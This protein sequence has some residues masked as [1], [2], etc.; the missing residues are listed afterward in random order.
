MVLSRAFQTDIQD[1]LEAFLLGIK[2]G[3]HF[4]I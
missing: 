1:V 3:R 2:L 4:G